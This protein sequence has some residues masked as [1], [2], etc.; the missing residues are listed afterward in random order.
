PTVL[1]SY[2]KMRF[3]VFTALIALSLTACDKLPTRPKTAFNADSAWSYTQQQVNF[4]PRVP[5]T[6]AAA[7]AGDWIVAMMKQRADTVI[8]QR[9]VHRTAKGDSLPL[10]N[11]LA[12]FRPQ[13]T[14]RILYVTHW[15]TR[16]MA[17][18][19]PVL[20]N[21]NTPILGANDGASGVGLFIA[22]GDAL[23]K[24][25]PNVGVD[26]L[27]V[28]GED[29]GVSFN[30][31]Y[32]DVLLGSQYF[33]SHL[34]APD[35]KP[36]YGVLWDMIADRYLN[37]L[38]E[39]RSVNAAPEVVSRVWEKANELGYSKYFIPSVGQDVIDDH[40]PFIEHGMRVIDVIDYDYGPPAPNG[41]AE[42]NYHHTL[43]DTMEHISKQSLQIVGDV[44]LALITQ[45]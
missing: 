8:E 21:R 6:P 19:D 13:A 14:Q 5:G 3:T 42:P 20:G 26:L 15:D 16:P 22:L 12:R 35:Y 31:P 9:W 38:Q 2:L 24:T 37:I 30:P 7:K 41:G 28:D 27:F 10:R 29:Y 18:S 44:A 45:G 23:K 43:G 4:G 40:V 1:L 17:D 34:P 36:M 33:V 25:P 11:I 32:V 39:V